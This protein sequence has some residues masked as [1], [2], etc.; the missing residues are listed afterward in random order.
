[1]A[2]MIL[3][4]GVHTRTSWTPPMLHSLLG[5]V[6]LYFNLVAFWREAKYMMEHNMLMEELDR[7]LAASQR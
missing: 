3:G 7:V 1:M 2:T 4:G 6:A 5:G